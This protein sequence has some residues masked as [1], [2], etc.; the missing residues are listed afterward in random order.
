MVEDIPLLPLTARGTVF[1]RA[2]EETLY[3]PDVSDVLASLGQLPLAMALN[4]SFLF[5][6]SDRTISFPFRFL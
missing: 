5:L 6:F 1:P 4:S 3:I 2:K